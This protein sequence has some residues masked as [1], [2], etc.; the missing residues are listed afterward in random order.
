MGVVLVGV[1]QWVVVLEPVVTRSTNIQT[2]VLPTHTK[3]SFIGQASHCNECC[4]V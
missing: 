4:V 1:V 3:K 2:L